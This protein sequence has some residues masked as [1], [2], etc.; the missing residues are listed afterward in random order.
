MA[1]NNAVFAAALLGLSGLSSIAQAQTCEDDFDCAQGYRCE[2]EGGGDVAVDAPSGAAAPACDGVG[3]I[4]PDPDPQPQPT[5]GTCTPLPKGL[6]LDQ[7]GCSTGLTCVIGTIGTACAEPA[8]ADPSGAPRPS[9][10]PAECTP[11]EQPAPY[12]VCA[13]PETKCTTDAQCL[14][15]LKCVESQSSDGSPGLVAPACPPNTPDCV[16]DPAPEPAPQPVDAVSTCQVAFDDCTTNAQCAAGYECVEKEVSCSS[17]G[18]GGGTVD[19]GTN[20]VSPGGT[21]EKQTDPNCAYESKCLPKFVACDADVQCQANWTCYAYDAN[22]GV[23]ELWDKEAAGKAC[24]PK[25]LALAAEAAAGLS[26]DGRGL[27]DDSTSAPETASDSDKNAAAGA[28]G[29]SSCAV[30]VGAGAQGAAWLM[31]IALGM[32]VRRRRG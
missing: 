22:S 5:T 24:L 25:G 20:P 8:P 29:S 15:G 1:R 9:D 6:C 23:G 27:N 10:Q 16:A 19:T 21:I 12:G 2:Y 4:K 26:A 13:L 7:A 31:A 32:L 17:Q 14:L 28:G 3:C 11:S 18:S 30:A